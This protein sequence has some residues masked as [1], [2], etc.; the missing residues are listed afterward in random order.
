MR[1][2]R[3]LIA[4]VGAVLLLTSTTAT[5]QTAC[6]PTTQP[7]RHSVDITRNS[8]YWFTHGYSNDLTCVNLQRAIIANGGTMSIGFLCLP[9]A[10]RNSDNVLDAADTFVEALGFYYRGKGVTGEPGGH[11]GDH[12][13]GSR[14]CRARKKLAVELIA[15][16]AN[17]VLL[18]TGPEYASYSSN[19][20]TVSFPPDLIDLAGIVA[21]GQD[22]VAAK[23][24]TSVLKK[25]NNSGVTNDFPSELVECSPNDK[26]T[27]KSI[28]RDPTTQFTCPGLNDNCAAAQEVFFQAKNPPYSKA[29]FTASANLENYPI[30][31]AFWKV[32]LPTASANRTFRVSTDGSNFD[33]ILN[34]LTGPCAL[35]ISN[36]TTVVDASGLT[37]VATATG[38]N[39]VTQISFTTDGTNTFFIEASPA[40]LA[41]PGNLKITVT[42]P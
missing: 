30:G 2:Y 15:A 26:R 25:F 5:A 20:V 38:S 10:N 21:A 1:T 9:T 6:L 18:G 12:S 11:Q 4:L 16:I 32:S 13:P 29:K 7:A 24:M 36:G 19:G 34:V 40:P 22:P 3:N 23:D 14:L 31:L 17:N 39:S 42:S 8:L 27:L 33:T 28:S 41:F 35:V 37:V